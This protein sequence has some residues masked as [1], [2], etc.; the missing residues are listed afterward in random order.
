VSR[1]GGGPGGCLAAGRP[2]RRGLDPPTWLLAE[3]GPVPSTPRSGRCGAWPPRNWTVIGAP[4]AWMTLGRRSIALLEW[5]S[6]SSSTSTPTS[7]PSCG[8]PAGTPSTDHP[9]LQGSSGAFGRRACVSRTQPVL[10]GQP[11]TA[12]SVTPAA[13]PSPPTGAA[14]ERDSARLLDRLGRLLGVPVGRKPE[15]RSC[16]GARASEQPRTR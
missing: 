5:N 15:I 6:S 9:T 7:P 2:A 11:V 3:L 10:P 4:T 16:C 1:S 13:P 8:A 12:A 14:G